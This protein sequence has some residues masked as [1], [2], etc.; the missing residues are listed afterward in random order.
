MFPAF[1]SLMNGESAGVETVISEVE[2]FTDLVIN[3]A[4]RFKIVLVASWTRTASG[5]GSGLLDW[6]ECGQAKVLA[7]MNVRL[8][9]LLEG[10]SNIRI[11]DSQRWLD[12]ARPPRDSRYW[13]AMKSPFTNAVTQ[14]AARDVK[15]AIRA[16]SGQAKK[17]I[18]LDLDDTLWGGVVGETGWE[19][20]RLGGHD[21]IGEAYLDFQRTLK[22]L[23]NFG[24][25]LGVVSKN[26][27]SVAMDVF[28]HHPEMVLRKSNLAGWRIN[29][30][31]KAANLRSLVLELNLGLQSVV[32]IDDSAIERGR[33]AEAFPEVLVPEWPADPTRYADTLRQL[34]CFDQAALTNDDRRRSVSYAQERERGESFRSATSHDEWLSGLGVQVRMAVVSNANIARVVQLANKTNQFNI[35]TRRFTEVELSS[36]LSAAPDHQAYAFN[37]A[38]RFGEIGLTAVVSYQRAGENLEIVDFLLSCRA[39]GRQVENL[40][41]HFVI[42]EA[43]KQGCEKVV[44]R[45]TSTPRNGP[46]IAFWKRSSFEEL[47]ENTFSWDV[48][49][50]YP[51]PSFIQAQV[52]TS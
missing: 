31:D 27:E 25:A 37:V 42:E 12:A 15:A 29:W 24:V 23:T 2:A 52:V 33:I 4:K 39:M 35:G 41:A 20:I 13:Y 9:N 30:D 40:M 47:E 10:Y 21:A 48:G 19:G 5:R 11:L 28:E 16:F 18:V 45:V 1:A 46:C 14:A 38:D 22:T 43:K 51:K 17:L 50:L 49:N 6:T 34:D 32:F 8:A 26:T 3:A 44:V 36:W 7:S